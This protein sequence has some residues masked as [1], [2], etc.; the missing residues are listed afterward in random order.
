[1]MRHLACVFLFCSVAWLLAGCKKNTGNATK[2]AP[3]KGTV[4]LDGKAMAGGEVRFSIAG[5]A[6]KIL[7]VKDGTFSGEAYVGK[8]HVEVVW[9]KDGPPHPMDPNTRLKVNAIAPRFSGPESPFKPDIP[10]GGSSDLKFDVT[11]R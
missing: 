5:Q 6:P 7:E 4:N 1:M 3:V 8:N 2:M 10:A 9:E 11:S